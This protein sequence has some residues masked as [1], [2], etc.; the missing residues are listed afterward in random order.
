MALRV[1]CG[2]AALPRL[3]SKHGFVAASEDA[4]FLAPGRFNQIHGAMA[5]GV[6]SMRAWGLDPGAFPRAL[7]THSLAQARRA[8]TL[9]AATPGALLQAGWSALQGAAVQGACTACYFRLRLAATAATLEAQNLGDCSLHLYR[10][11]SLVCAAEHTHRAFDTPFQLGQLPG[12]APALFQGPGHAR[13]LRAALAP[14]DSLL[15][16]SDGVTDNMF[17][18]EIKEHFADASRG[19]REVARALVAHAHE[20]AL[21]GRRD[22]PFALAAKDADV[23][24]SAGGR[25]DDITVIVLQ[26]LPAG[27]AALDAQQL[28]EVQTLPGVPRALLPVNLYA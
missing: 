3:S 9:A 20:R 19:A 21:D 6:G 16:C 17:P 25:M 18:H 8:T 12:A 28:A 22:G 2:I 24:W 5:D 10:A 13:S 7:L 27:S 1:R 23:L 14:G 11:G 15:I 4:F 26:L